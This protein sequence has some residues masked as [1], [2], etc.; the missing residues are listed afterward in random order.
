MKHPC[1]KYLLPR[2][3]EKSKKTIFLVLGTFREIR[4]HENKTCVT[5]I[6]LNLLGNIFAFWEANFVSAAMF[7]EV[8][9]Q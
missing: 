6:F 9:K 5:K 8:G 2:K 1:E 4:K 7:S 3:S